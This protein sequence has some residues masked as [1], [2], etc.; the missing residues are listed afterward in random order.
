MTQRF[1][2]SL[3]QLSYFVECARTLNM[4]LASQEMHVAQSAVSTAIT[5]LERSLGAVLFIRQRSKGLVLTAAG[6]RLLRDTRQLF[7]MLSDSID[8]IREDQT[9]VQGTISI[10]CFTTLSPV[11]LPRLLQRIEQRH[12]KLAVEVLEGDYSENLAALR[13][14]QVELAIDYDLTSETDIRRD[15][16]G[17]ARPYI[18]VSASHRLAQSKDTRLA[19]LAGEDFILLDLPSSSHY[20]IN[21]LR[22]AGITP[23]V[24]YQSSSFETVR[25]MVAAGL[26]YSILNQ[27]PHISTTYSGESIAIVEIADNVPSLRISVDSLSQFEMST[28]AKAV[29]QEVRGVLAEF[30]RDRPY[31]SGAGN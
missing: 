20:F 11:L 30:S 4:T 14:G 24:R 19:K 3:T 15:I 2:V 13:A 18:L 17:Q 7:A 29:T 22:H 21:L 5:H 12:P 27:R 25:S 10:A 23:H 26:G 31:R 1:P 6:E 28:R 16:V 8:S 9:H